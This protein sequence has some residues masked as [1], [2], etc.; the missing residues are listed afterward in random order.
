MYE[1]A[2]RDLAPDMIQP[3]D[4][5]PSHR[6]DVEPEISPGTVSFAARPLLAIPMLGIVDVMSQHREEPIVESMKE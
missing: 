1:D 4:K 5:N 6:R 3:R 2:I